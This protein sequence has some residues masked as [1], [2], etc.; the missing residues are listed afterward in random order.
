M[1]LVGVSMT[2]RWYRPLLAV[3]AMSMALAGG[4]S[5]LF[6]H[7]ADVAAAGSHVI[8]VKEDGFNPKLCTV[9]R[10]D[11]VQWKNIGTTTR[12]VIK[13]D[14]GVGSPPLFDSGDIL[15]GELS[16]SVII[17]AG[18]NF[19]YQDLYNPALTGTIYNSNTGSS[20]A[21]CS[22]LPPTPTPTLTPTPGPSKTPTPLATPTPRLPLYCK[23]QAL[24][25]TRG[26]EGCVVAPGV[27]RDDE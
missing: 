7:T 10:D 22:P 21:N 1:G 17:T 3:V 13:P 4:L 8:E 20:S 25:A 5:V 9:R 16:Q 12:R 23:A 19:N 24:G 11:S 27:A 26:N 14:A 6:S 15:P 2:G 18:G